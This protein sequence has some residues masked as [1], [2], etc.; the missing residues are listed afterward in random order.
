MTEATA[1]Q[2]DHAKINQIKMLMVISFEWYNCNQS[3]FSDTVSVS[4]I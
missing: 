4:L 1:D 2:P 3:D